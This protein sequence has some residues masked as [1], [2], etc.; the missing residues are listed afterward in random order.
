MPSVRDVER[1]QNSTSALISEEDRLTDEVA[2]GDSSD[3]EIENSFKPASYLHPRKGGPE[4]PAATTLAQRE[5]ATA[6]KVIGN[7]SVRRSAMATGA[8]VSNKRSRPQPS[9]LLLEDEI[10]EDWLDKD[11]PSPPTRKLAK[12]SSTSSSSSPWSLQE[13]DKKKSTTPS[14]NRLSN[15]TKSSNATPLQKS[16]ISLSDEDDLDDFIRSDEGPS[17]KRSKPSPTIQI[18]DDSNDRVPSPV[19]SGPR[20]QKRPIQL[21]M[22][23]FTEVSSRKSSSPKVLAQPPPPQPPA[24]SP[25]VESPG[26]L[27]L[28]V[29]VQDKVLLIP[30][31]RNKT[32]Q[33]LSEEA[34]RR[35]YN[36]TGA[37]KRNYIT[38]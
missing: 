31:E 1:K 26:V 34:A 29:R 17:A 8:A 32:V 38:F 23:A 14:A 30:A 20:R 18:S 10:E 13:R 7:S 11:V 35:Y 3:C 15:R 37:F 27:K 2:L 19:L 22:D 21:S 36:M 4:V 16:P 5:Y 6:M 25:A 12:K 33:W 24:C 28:Y 9:A